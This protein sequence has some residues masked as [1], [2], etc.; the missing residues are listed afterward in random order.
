MQADGR[1]LLMQSSEA[2]AALAQQAALDRAEF[3]EFQRTTQAALERIERVL[4]YLMQRD[5]GRPS[6]CREQ[7]AGFRAGACVSI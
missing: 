1:T 5:P 4:D 7:G 3:G 2:V 6:R